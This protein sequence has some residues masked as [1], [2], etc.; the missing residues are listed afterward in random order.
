ML[1]EIC[2]I[3]HIFLK[4]LYIDHIRIHITFVRIAMSSVVNKKYRITTLIHI[5]HHLVIF[6]CKLTET[7]GYDNR[8]L[9]IRI[10]YILCMYSA[11]VPAGKIFLTDI[12]L[13]QGQNCLLHF[14]L[15][16]FL[17][18]KEVFFSPGL[19]HIITPNY[20]YFSAISRALSG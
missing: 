16:I 5:V 9:F 18:N 3:I 20:L 4:A 19:T 11:P 8:C 13:K 12:C 7:M 2:K 17:I 6:A 14:S 15:K 1:Y 10:N